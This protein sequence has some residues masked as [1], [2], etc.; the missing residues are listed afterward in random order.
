MLVN[1][2]A[3]QI[4]VYSGSG[5]NYHRILRPLRITWEL[6]LL[7]FAARALVS[8]FEERAGSSAAASFQF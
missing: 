6:L 3:I 4:F 7:R 5:L 8:S 1:N 2:T